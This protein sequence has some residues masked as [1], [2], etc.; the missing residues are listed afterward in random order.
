MDRWF[1]AKE[2][3]RFGSIGILNLVCSDTN[4]DGDIISA[5]YENDGKLKS[6][7]SR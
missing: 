6:F 1:V 5:T 4:F 7:I 3:F 2:N